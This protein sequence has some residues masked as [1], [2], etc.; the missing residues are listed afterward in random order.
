[1]YLVKHCSLNI[2]YLLIVLY[3]LTK[4]YNVPV[5]FGVVVG[6][7]VGGGRT[8][9]EKITVNENVFVQD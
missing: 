2:I 5:G 3:K 4:E 6:K 9:T 1:M 7:V 8:E